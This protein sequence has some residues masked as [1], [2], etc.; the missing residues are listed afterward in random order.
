MREIASLAGSCTLDDRNILELDTGG[1]CTTLNIL[2]A[3][4]LL[5]LNWL[6]KKKFC[7][8]PF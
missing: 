3:T 7:F 4:E 8:I 6:I 2:N 1:I 5:T